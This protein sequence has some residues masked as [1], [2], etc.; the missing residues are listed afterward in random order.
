LPGFVQNSFP[1]HL[2][3]GQMLALS[4]H[5]NPDKVSEPFCRYAQHTLLPESVPEVSDSPIEKIMNCIARGQVDPI[6]D[7]I[8]QSN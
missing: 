8:F 4:H 5:E 3:E 2:L 1:D 7:F 6:H